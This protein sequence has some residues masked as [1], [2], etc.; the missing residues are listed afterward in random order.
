VP[1]DGRNRY[2]ACLLADVEP[3]FVETD[4]EGMSPATYVWLLNGP[5]RHMTK[6]QLAIVGMRMKEEFA[7]EAKERQKRKPKDSVVEMFPQQ[8]TGGNISTS[9]GGRARD[10][11]GATVEDV[12]IVAS[13][14]AVEAR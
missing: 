9:D 8:N 4:L 2:R 5:R 13:V 3:D 7:K 1:I 6:T 14:L 11:A 12:L 10:K